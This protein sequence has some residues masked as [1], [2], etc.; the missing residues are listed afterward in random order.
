MID[1]VKST[2]SGTTLSIE[3]I[4]KGKDDPSL[5]VAALVEYGDDKG[6]GEYDFKTNRDGTSS[7]YLKPRPF[8]DKT[9]QELESGKARSSFVEGLKQ[10]GLTV[11]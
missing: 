9:H 4:T 1:T 6:Y 11:K 8:Q 5:D 2:A 10:Q 7:Q 3:N